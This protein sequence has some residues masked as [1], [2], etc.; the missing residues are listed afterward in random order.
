MRVFVSFS[1]SL[2]KIMFNKF[3][4]YYQNYLRLDL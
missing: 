2:K 4:G 3:I 1:D